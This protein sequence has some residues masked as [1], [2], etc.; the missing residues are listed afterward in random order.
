MPIKHHYSA[1]SSPKNMS[2]I[3]VLFI[4]GISVFKPCASFYRPLPSLIGNSKIKF[5]ILPLE[6][7]HQMISQSCQSDLEL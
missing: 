1:Q 5:K 7:N 2:K 4:I 6:G 3:F